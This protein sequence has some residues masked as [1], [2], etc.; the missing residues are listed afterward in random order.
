MRRLIKPIRIQNYSANL[1]NP[2]DL[3]VRIDNPA[4]LFLVI[5][6]DIGLGYAEYALRP[7]YCTVYSIAKTQELWTTNVGE[8]SPTRDEA[9][10]KY[11][12]FKPE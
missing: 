1:I 8:Y 3:L 7:I 12:I 6:Q 9:F 4:E 10:L 11:K 5:A 2:G